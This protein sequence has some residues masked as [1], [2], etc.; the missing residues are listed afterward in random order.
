MI[1]DMTGTQKGDSC[2]LRGELHKVVSKSVE[3]KQWTKAAK[4][5]WAKGCR[6]VLLGSRA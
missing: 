5:T 1:A 6:K 4:P 2:G 3:R